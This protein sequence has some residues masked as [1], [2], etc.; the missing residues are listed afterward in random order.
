[1]KIPYGDRRLGPAILLGAMLLAM[2]PSARQAQAGQTVPSVTQTLLDK[3]KAFEARGR[4]DLAKQTW[5]QILLADPN[6]AGALGGLARAAKLEGNTAL[7]NAYLDKLRAVNPN[8]PNLARMED[9]SAQQSQT[10]QLQQAGKLATNGQYASAMAIYRQVFGNNP[11]P[12]GWALAYYET[13]SATE[14]GRA[15]AIAGLTALVKQYPNDSLYQIA[16]GRILTYNPGTR[17]EGRRY[18]ERFPGDA[19][20]NEAIRQS[21]LWDSPNP[22]MAAQIRAYLATHR[23]PQLAAAVTAMSAQ[24]E[25]DAVSGRS[26]GGGRPV[27]TAVLARRAQSAAEIAAYKALNAKRTGEAETRFKA[28]LAKSPENAKALAGIGYVRM[29]QGNFSGAISYLEQARQEDSND[30][31]LNAALDTSRFW[32]VMGE[33][34]TAIDNNDLTTAEARYRAA[35]ELRPGNADA[36]AGLGGT[37]LKAGQSA[38]AIPLFQ[39]LV[40][41]RPELA[42]GWR[43]LFLA[44]Y[45]MGN[46]AQALVTERQIPAAAHTQLM[47]EPGFLQALAAAYTAVGRDSDAQRV[48]QMAL[49]APFAS[50]SVG[51]KA[52]AQLQYAGLLLAG[53][54]LDQA[55]SIYRQVL[56]ADHANTSAWQGLVRTE[57]AMGHDAEA[58]QTVES[59]PPANYEMAMHD[60]G[61]ETTV[62]SVYQAEKKLDV[63]QDLLEKA[64]AQQ[65][66][67][68]QRQ[69][70]AIQMQLAGVYMLRGQGALAQPVYRR[71]LIE[72]PE[73][74]DAWAGLLAVLHTMGQD[75]EAIDQVQTIAPAVRAQ[76]EQN[77]GYLQTMASVY[78]S[79]GQSREAAQFLARVEQYYA[80]AHAAAPADVEIQ[81]AWLLYNGVDDAGLYRQL[82]ALGGRPDLSDEQRRTVQTIWTNWAVRRAN[83]AVAAGDAQRALAILNAAAHAFP[84]NPAVLK[85]LANGYARAGQPA[86]AVLIYKA[87]NMASASA[88]DYE[89]A[90][91]AA[92]AAGDGKDAEAWLRLALAAYPSDPQVLMLAAKFEQTRGDTA[93]AI[94]YYHRSLKAMPPANPG[95]ELAAE[96]NLPPAPVPFYL[97]SAGRAEDLSSLLAPGSDDAHGQPYLPSYQPS[98]LPGYGSPPQ[99]SNGAAGMVPSYMTNPGPGSGASKGAQP[100]G[101]GAGRPIQYGPPQSRVEKRAATNLPSQAEVQMRV[102]DA[103]AAALAQDAGASPASLGVAREGAATIPGTSKPASGVVAAEGQVVRSASPAMDSGDSAVSPDAYRR[104]QL[105]RLAEQ[106]AARPPLPSTVAPEAYGAFV[107]YVAPAVNVASRGPA[108]AVTPV[109]LGDETPHPA[110]PVSEVTD[111][112]PTAHY[113]PNAKGGPPVSM[114]P[115]IAAA[116]AASIRRQQSDPGA[117]RTGY[118]P[119]VDVAATEDAVY[120]P[121]LAAQS[122]GTPQVPQPAM[123]PSGGQPEGQSGTSGSGAQQYSQPATPA[124]SGASGSG[125]PA[126][127][128]RVVRRTP[129][130]AIPGADAAA[131]A[132]ETPVVPPAAEAP[133]GMYSPGL[134]QALSGEQYPQIRPMYSPVLPPVGP[135]YGQGP[136]LSDAELVA[137][138]LPPLRGG[139]YRAQAP[140]PMTPR[141]E[142]ENELASLEGSYSS[143]LGGTGIGRYRGGTPGLDRLFDI[144]S[145]VE[146]SAALGRVA[147]L[148]VVAQPVFLNSGTLNPATF[149]AYSA[150]TVPYLGTLPANAANPPA[151]QLANGVGGELQLTTKNI[152]LAAGYTPY[153]FPVQNITGRFSWRP[154]GGPFTI[155]GDRSAVKD[156]QLSYAGMR[157]PGTVSPT[158]AGNIWGG[159]VSTLGGIKLDTGKAGSGFYVSGEGGVLKGDHVLTNNKFEGA[160]GAYFRVKNWP[161]YGSLTLGGALFGMHYAHNELGLTY[162]QG[163]YFS[164]NEYFLASVPVTFNGF[165]GQNLHYAIAGALGVQTFQQSAAPFYPLDPALQAGVQTTL[166]CTLPQLAAHNCG[167]FPV[168]GNTGFNYALNSEV[169]YLF[170]EHWF[171]GAFLAGNNTNN[172]NTVSGGFFFR[173]TLRRQRE[174]DGHPTGLFPVEGFRPVRIP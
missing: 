112:I 100:E 39:S 16:L 38:A 105:A 134:G 119:A 13:E 153:E 170:G 172:Y 34:Q 162:G 26:S 154:A 76:L 99:P 106:A 42:D 84:D 3:A 136:G 98:Y 133:Q 49:A 37:L 57:H 70:V 96:L 60:P 155:F 147:R 109:H 1:M 77:V 86:E 46:A 159:V 91:G 36:M 137:R 131:P 173:Y 24:A 74:A 6:N 127:R 121:G 10:A 67:S 78:A 14:D 51:A 85:A 50:D 29:Q 108:P 25:A 124:G 93:R 107:P 87:Q 68:G 115:D 166:A 123:R 71:V 129:S 148:T 168:S 4:I 164:P 126:V 18:L 35:L 5:Q 82:M 44:Q 161:E 11:P 9:T 171:L 2:L 53:N 135:A 140:M 75:K 64:L 114:H 33:G 95:A 89:A 160:M 167:E 97:P 69:S 73:R 113:V 152:G 118:S 116:Q 12:G 54:R 157:D 72:Y 125:A 15:H 103:I 149:A 55:V 143:W 79:L 163:G 66:T 139:G 83:Q 45:Q 56:A 8:D 58:M 128:R 132:V 165:Y 32:F 48:L 31:N 122:S 88:A 151:Q 138:N 61:F 144:E 104:E 117:A 27:G 63:A 156:T 150:I 17:Q 7:S 101:S 21:L 94:E 81:N 111:V 158:Y 130:A 120:A 22:A 65:A 169:S 92:L 174:A 59:M 19:Q 62:A 142:A 23:D 40:K 47:Q 145:P 90:V 110:P 52:D 30:K 80:A 102:R 20:A 141:Q 146:A 28:I 43:G 41:Q